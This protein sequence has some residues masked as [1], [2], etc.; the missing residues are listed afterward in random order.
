M[1]AGKPVLCSH[2]T[3][4]PEVAG[5]AA[6]YFDP[7]KPEQ[8]ADAIARIEGEP[9]LQTLLAR[10]SEQRAREL[11]SPARMAARYLD[12]FQETIAGG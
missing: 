12:I 5:D 6:L 2:T 4:L 1:A 10:Q 8:I 7:R 11:G 9:G 3:S